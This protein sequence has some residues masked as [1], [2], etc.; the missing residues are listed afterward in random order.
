LKFLWQAF[1]DCVSIES[2][3]RLCKSISKCWVWKS[4]HLCACIPT[5]LQLATLQRNMQRR[6]VPPGPDRSEQAA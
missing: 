5:M 6:R 2:T 4:F 3:A 1:Q